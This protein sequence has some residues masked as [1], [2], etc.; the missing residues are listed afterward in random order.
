M[1]VHLHQPAQVRF[2][3]Q[4]YTYKVEESALPGYSGAV[5]DGDN[6]EPT[7]NADGTL[8]GPDFTNTLT[9]TVNINGTKT[10]DGGSGSTPILTLQRSTNGTD[11]ETAT[12]NQPNW[13][14]TG[15]TQTYTYTGLPKYN[16]NGMLYQY[17][18]H[19]NSSG[20]L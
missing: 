10:W 8:E 20:W 1:E 17:P 18:C 3:G 19:R 4:E 14:G 12:D 9:G 16:E 5:D 15:S 11:W 6:N 13:T 2:G 7:T